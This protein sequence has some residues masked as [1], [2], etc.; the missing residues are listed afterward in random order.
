M[1]LAVGRNVSLIVD[2]EVMLSA[3]VGADGDRQRVTGS[4]NL[5]LVPGTHSF[6]VVVE[7]DGAV[8]AR[9]ILYTVG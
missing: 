5:G 4:P 3:S 8:E 7:R 6:T 2:D 1:F 9:S